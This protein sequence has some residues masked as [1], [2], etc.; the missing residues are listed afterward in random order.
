MKQYIEFDI[1]ISSPLKF[2]KF[3]F[4]EWLKTYYS[5]T[6]Y[7]EPMVINEKYLLYKTILPISFIDVISQIE[8]DG[9][10]VWQC[11]S[12]Q[13]NINDDDFL[14]NKKVDINYHEIDDEDFDI[15]KLNHL[16]TLIV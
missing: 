7:P 10:I 5:I 6:D 2:D 4:K 13:F 12:K 14:Y 15:Q 9:H 3:N 8:N 11:T 16:D 1:K